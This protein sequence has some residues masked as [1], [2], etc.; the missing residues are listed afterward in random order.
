MLIARPV[1]GRFPLSL[2]LSHTKRG[3]E[4][5]CGET[6]AKEEPELQSARENRPDLALRTGDRSSLLPGL[7]LRRRS[8]LAGKSPAEQKRRQ[9]FLEWAYIRTTIG[10][11]GRTKAP[12]LAIRLMQH[13]TSL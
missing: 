4:R 10:I 8:R 5:T 9:T 13:R 7:A 6:K 1:A 2:T 12:K 11:A 3:G